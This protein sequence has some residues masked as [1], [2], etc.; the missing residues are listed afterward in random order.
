MLKNY[1]EALR[2]AKSAVSLEKKLSKGWLRITRCCVKLGDTIAARKA[3]RKLNHLGEDDI[4]EKSNIEEIER[5][6]ELSVLAK[7]RNDYK[8]SLYSIKEALKIAKSSANLKRSM[9]ECL[10]LLGRIKEAKTV[11][12]SLS[13][14]DLSDNSSSYVK[15]LCLY[16]EGTDMAEAII[17]FKQIPTFDPSHRKAKEILSVS[18]V[19]PILASILYT[20]LTI[21]NF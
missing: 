15:G 19:D 10:V 4:Y 14:T 6:E 18:W 16:Y 11:I 9:V 7:N 13:K 20:L 3:L 2:D 17:L 1:T 12:E 8:T 5:L 21:L